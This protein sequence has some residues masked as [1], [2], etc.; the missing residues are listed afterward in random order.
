MRLL[1][2]AYI[3]L[4]ANPTA[5]RSSSLIR[6][7]AGVDEIGQGSCRRT[8]DRRSACRRLV[9]LIQAVATVREVQ[10][11]GKAA[12]VHRPSIE[13]VSTLPYET[14]R[15]RAKG[16]LQIKIADIQAASSYVEEER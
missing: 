6:S 10:G 4:S 13:G 7:C 12:L 14:L 1:P 9:T 8:R 15:A 2:R 5:G 3:D 11:D 16:G